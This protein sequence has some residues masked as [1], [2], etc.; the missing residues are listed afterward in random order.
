MLE[1]AGADPGEI[2]EFLGELADALFADNLASLDKTSEGFWFTLFENIRGA[3]R[4]LEK[5]VT[6]TIESG[7]LKL[8]WT[9]SSG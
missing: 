9:G 8:R 1:L 4:K 5:G 3:L 2:D 6:V 7:P